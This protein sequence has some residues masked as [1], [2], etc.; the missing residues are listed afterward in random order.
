MITSQNQ[1]QICI[2]DNGV[3]MEEGGC[4]ATAGNG[5]HNMQM[6]VSEI[7]CTVAWKRAQP[8]GTEVVLQANTI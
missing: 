1:W 2:R 4:S 6:R 7:N 8:S 5:L 3:G